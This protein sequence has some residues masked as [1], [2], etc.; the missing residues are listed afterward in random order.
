MLGS[1]SGL[2]ISENLFGRFGGHGNFGW[3]VVA[4]TWILWVILI[5][6]FNFSFLFGSESDWGAP[7]TA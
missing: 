2:G 1:I 6:R 4:S 3:R 5:I 7:I